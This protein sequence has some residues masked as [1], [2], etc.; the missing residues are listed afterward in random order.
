LQ[1]TR[2]A[3]ERGLIEKFPNGR[4]R[5]GAPKL[6]GDKTVARAQ[7]LMEKEIMAKRS[8]PAIPVAGPPA[9]KPWTLA[10]RV[11]RGANGVQTRKGAASALRD[12]PPLEIE[13]PPC[14]DRLRAREGVAMAGADR[15]RERLIELRDGMLDRMLRKGAVEPGHLPLIA[16]A[17][18]A[19]DALGT[20]SVEMG[21]SRAVVS[22]DGRE[23]RLT[24]YHE[25]EA[26]AAVLLSPERAIAL[27]GRLLDAAGLRLASRIDAC[28]SRDMTR[29]ALAYGVSSRLRP[30]ALPALQGASALRDT[31]WRSG[32]QP[33]AGPSAPLPPGC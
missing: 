23:I 6:S 31:A 16:G 2:L 18:A 12:A 22:D 3:K 27:A 10:T 13:I 24:L 32:R 29:P 4:R 25:A 5:R 11:M 9:E 30:A 14:P 7:R 15:L 28:T 17:S 8:L 26:V 20:L 1:R 19:L 21:A 33:A